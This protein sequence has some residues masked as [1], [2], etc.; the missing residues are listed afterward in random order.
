M[1]LSVDVVF[2]PKLLSSSRL[3]GKTVVVTDILRATTTITVA[4]AN[5]AC[6]VTP[7]LTPADAFHFVDS[8]PIAL[9]GG[10]R[11]GIKVNG[12][13][14]GNSPREYTK[15]V[16]AGR[17]VVLTTTNGTRTLCACRTAHRVLVGCFLNL[18]SVVDCLKRVPGKIVIACSGREGSFCLEDTVFAGA[19]ADALK[20]TAGNLKSDFQ[21]TDAAEAA[22]ILYHEY[23]RDL[24]GMLKM[25]YHGKHL[26]DVGLGGDLAFC[27]QTNV[28]DIVPRQI[29]GC[30][31]A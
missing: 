4:L 2:T 11:E 17:P 29:D 24:I 28:I 8:T 6:S 13:D 12:F 3:S 30:I 7:V 25:C 1:P 14:L 16:V 5:G 15:S 18:R 21:V 20:C 23:R 26:T 19:C 31:I 22:R 10:E 27:A 9:I